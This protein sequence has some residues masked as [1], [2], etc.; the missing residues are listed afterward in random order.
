[1]I[2]PFAGIATGIEEANMTVLPI[3]APECYGRSFFVPGEGPCSVGCRLEA[4]CK[5]KYLGTA[6]QAAETGAQLDPD[7]EAFVLEHTGPAPVTRRQTPEEIAAICEVAAAVVLGTEPESCRAVQPVPAVPTEQ[8]RAQVE[9]AAPIPLEA[10][11]AEL[12]LVPA[13]LGVPRTGEPQDNLSVL[14]AEVLREA[15]RPLH[16]REVTAKL[17]ALARER[18]VRLAGKTP[19][20]TVGVAVRR[21][22]GVERVG[23]GMY[24]W[25]TAR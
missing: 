18:G 3:D 6:R 15:G 10:S 16:V 7:E 8:D 24:R 4:S 20:A 5:A 13:V 12:E 2:G 23:R 9:P 19:E 21:A 14:A 11:S 17:T 22:R 1:M 25:R